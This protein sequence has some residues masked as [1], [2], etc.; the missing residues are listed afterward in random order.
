MAPFHAQSLHGSS[1]Y[2]FLPILKNYFVKLLFLGSAY[3]VSDH[4]WEYKCFEGE[5]LYL[6]EKPG[7]ALLAPLW[8]IDWFGN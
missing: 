4:S 5:Y 8:F 7:A 2:K 1:Q 3:D 6:A